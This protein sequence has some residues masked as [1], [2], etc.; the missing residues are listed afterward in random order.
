MKAKFTIPELDYALD[1]LEPTISRQTME[2]HYGKHLQGYLDN[3]NGLI[4][5]SDFQKASLEDLIFSASG[6]LF[7]NGAQVWNHIFYFQT[8]SPNPQAAPTGALLQAI[9]HSFETFAQF[10]EEFE[11][12]AAS[13]FGSGWLWLAKDSMDELHIIPRSNAENPLRDGLIPL[14][15][16]DLWEHAYYLDYQNRRAEHVSKIWDVVDWAVVERR[17]VCVD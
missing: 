14:L 3:L 15:T 12:Q 6:A 8:L 4:A 9:E 11:R 13:L 17:Y 5:D 2:L 10:R 16:F 1:A 7:N